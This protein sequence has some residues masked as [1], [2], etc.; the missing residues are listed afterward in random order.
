MYDNSFFSGP[1]QATS[2]R[3]GRLERGY[4]RAE[5]SKGLVTDISKGDCEMKSSGNL[6]PQME[7][8]AESD[9]S[10]ACAGKKLRSRNKSHWITTLKK[11]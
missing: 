4:H 1:N 8:D 9:N 5:G 10:P 6:S 2:K 11:I 7:R 3:L